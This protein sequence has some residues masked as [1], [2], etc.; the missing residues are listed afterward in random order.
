MQKNVEV[1]L[2]VMNIQDEKQFNKILKSNN[3]KGQVL[4]VN[5]VEGNE[6]IF[7]IEQSRKRLYSYNEKG[8]SKSRNRLLENANGDICIFADDDMVYSKEYEN[9]IKLEYEKNKKADG[10]IFYVENENKNR[11]K[12]KIIGNKK[13]NLFDIMK[14]RTYEITLRKETIKKIKKQKIKF[15]SN[16]G[17]KGIFNKGEETIF[18]STLLKNGFNIYSVDKKIGTAQNDTSTWF[19]GFDEKYLYDQGAIFFKIA[20]KIYKL[21]ILQYIVRK[22][23]QY[24]RNVKIIDAYK[25][26][27]AG[28]KKCKEIYGDKENG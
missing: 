22:Y 10:I 16:F 21:L 2:S 27:I 14:V 23:F 24:R 1:L 4:A 19:T 17:P 11:E 6:R 28:A 26:M 15:D 7:N 18:L 25:Q 3:I 12:N 20:P 5:Q 9:I 13:I 8:A